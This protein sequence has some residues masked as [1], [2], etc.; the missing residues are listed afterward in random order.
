MKTLKKTK[1]RYETVPYV[2]RT[3]Y[4]GKTI[5][6]HKYYSSRYGRQTSPNR[7]PHMNPTPIPVAE[8]N[9]QNAIAKLR[10]LLNTNF[11]FGD[12]HAVF[13][14]RKEDRPQT[15]DEAKKRYAKLMRQLKKAYKKAGVEHK[16]IAVTE[17]E[18]T[19]IHHH[20]VLKNIDV[21]FIKECWRWGKVMMTV[22][23][24]TGQYSK[25]AE[26]LIKETDKT[27]KNLDAVYKKRWNASQNLTKPKVKREIV[28]ANSWKEEPKPIKGYFLWKDNT[29]YNTIDQYTGSPRQDYI[30]VKLE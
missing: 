8:I 22:L 17:Y 14:Y 24:N 5:E 13:T 11:E 6:V 18:N 7:K 19:A 3:V 20:I 15:I 4:A 21:C 26:Y 29:A 27:S 10:G 1:G 23:D 25:L 16:Y 28:S 2:K 9:R 12:I 30:M